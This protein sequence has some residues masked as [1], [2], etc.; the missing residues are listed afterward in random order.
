MKNISF[1]DIEERDLPAIKSL[2]VEAFGEGWNLGS[3]DQDSQLFDALLETYLSMFLNSATFGKVA[4]VEDKVVGAVLCSAVG[5]MEKF[6][7]FQRDRVVHTLA[8]LCADERERADIAEHLSV[9]FQAIGS[10]LDDK[11]DK[12]DGSLEFIAV[13]KRAQG[14]KIGKTLWNEAFAYFKSQGAETVY[15]IADSQCSTGFYDHNGFTKAA[16]ETATY[17]YT[18]G[19]KQFYIYVYEYKF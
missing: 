10:L 8:L 5:D 18:A 6:R 7:Q 13:S 11:T 15:L 4:T 1:R 16:S 3:F 2:I 17:N 14:L 12:Y 9:S 19:Q